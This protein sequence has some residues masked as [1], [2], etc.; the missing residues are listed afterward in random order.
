MQDRLSPGCVTQCG[1]GARFSHEKISRS[2]VSDE[3]QAG[4]GI[5]GDALRPARSSAWRQVR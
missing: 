5:Y 2:R 4:L 1:R 3:A